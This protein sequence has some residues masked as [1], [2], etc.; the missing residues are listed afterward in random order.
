MP[1]P[2]SLAARIA[3]AFVVACKWLVVLVGV[4]VFVVI[5]PIVELAYELADLA[6]RAFARLR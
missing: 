6:R 4:V 1:S 5:V 3:G 2:V